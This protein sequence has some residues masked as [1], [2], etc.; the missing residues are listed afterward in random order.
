M[1]PTVA[2]LELDDLLSQLVDRAQDV[3]ATQGR[4]R[5]LLHANRVIATD[6][7]LPVLLRHIVEAATDL[8]GARYGALGVVAPDRTLEEFVH[9]GMTDADVERIGHLP[10]G[11]GLLGILI[12]D[13]RPRRADDIAHDPASQGF[14]AGHPPMRTFL[15]VPITVRGEV[16]GNLYLTD[17]RDGVPFTAEDEELAQ[18][19]AANAGV[20]IANAR[21]YHE[22]QQRHLW[23]TASAE[24]SRQVMVG[25]DNALA[26]LVHRVQEVADAP[27]V[28]LALHT[29]NQGT[30]DGG[31]R[32]K[33]AGYARVAVAVTERHV[34][35]SAHAGLGTD[36]SRAGRLIPL[37]HT[38][39][40]RVIAEQQA[41]RVD[42]SE[43]DALPDE[44]AARTGPLMVVP[45]VAGGDQCGGALL[46]GRDRGVR[47][48]TD[49]D[50]DMAAG[51]AGHVAVALELARARADQEHLRV[52]A[53]RGRIARD[54]HDHVIQRMF[55]VA[56]GMQDL[57]QYENPSNAGRLNG[58]V[59]DID[60]TIKDIRRSIFELRGQSPTKRG[61]LRAGLNKIA[62]DVR[63]ALGFAPA[64]SLTGPLDTVADD[65]LTDHLLAVT[66]EALTNTARHAHATSVEVRLAVDGDMVTL[67]A[68]DN[69]VGIGD[70]TRRSGLD[71]LRARAE[72]L[73][74]TFTATT[75]PTGGTHLR[76]AAPF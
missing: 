68:V 50:L 67:D 47:A 53:D 52:L 76:W 14:P 27:F 44:R 60:A 39:T 73:G 37:E 32:S 29:T 15:G 55:A 34:T 49:G 56:L 2:R 18:A 61:R 26:T 43:L 38:L 11:H 25:A 21:L 46:I 75:P 20:A 74:G 6:L 51:F 4:L 71:N 65:Q 58:Y 45:L 7:R 42:D 48:F 72:S 36:A 5:G 66:R 13:P 19:L 54:L 16:F 10:T 22:A 3:L 62:D 69:G 41:L 1:F 17:K 31:D 64:I 9:V 57:A 33:E 70:T 63:L 23:M 40:G 24:I 35:G 8:L 12:D 30:A 28:A 59:E